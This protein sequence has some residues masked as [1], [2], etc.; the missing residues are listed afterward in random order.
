MTT[1]RKISK[2]LKSRPTIEGAGVHLKRAFAFREVPMFDPFL[3]VRRFSIERSREVSQGVPLAPPPRD[4][5]DHVRAPRKGRAR[6]QHGEPRLH[7]TRRCPVDDRG[8]RDHP[9]GDAEGGRFR[10]D[11]GVPAL[12][13][14]PGVAQDDGSPVPRR[15][16]RRDPGGL[17][18]GR[19][20]GSS[21]LRRS[22]GNARTGPRHRHRSRISRRDGPRG[23]E[24]RSSD[25]A[26]ATPSSRM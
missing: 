16:D 20:E 23:H 12:G 1:T 11:G 13:Q 6:G 10:A 18:E 17:P 2:V 26:R 15:E 3:L 24:V 21:H 22:R 9:S 4:R 5:D 14:S 25:P 8:E 7:R 19:R